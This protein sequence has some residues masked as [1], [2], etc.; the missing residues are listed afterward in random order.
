MKD[1]L[2]NKVDTDTLSNYATTEA[3]SNHTS[4]ESL[5]VTAEEKEKWNNNSSNTSISSEEG[6]I[7][8]KKSDGLYVPKTDLSTY[9]TTDDVEAMITSDLDL[10]KLA[11]TDLCYFSGHHKPNENETTTGYHVTYYTKY[12]LDQILPMNY[13]VKANG[14]TVNETGEI[15]LPANKVFLVQLNCRMALT[16]P[17]NFIAFNIYNKTE[18]KYESLATAIYLDYTGRKWSDIAAPCIIKTTQE[19]VIY[20]YIC[21]FFGTK[22]G[23]HSQTT[24][25]I[26]ELGS[27]NTINVNNTYAG[28]NETVLFDGNANTAKTDYALTDSIDNYDLIRIECRDFYEINYMTKTAIY[29]PADIVTMRT[30]IPFEIYMIRPVA[31]GTLGNQIIAVF[32]DRSTLRV[33]YYHDEG[34]YYKSGISRIVGIKK[35]GETV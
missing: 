19:T 34:N 8:E 4:D 11:G 20:A 25:T 33:N 26:I 18:N 7:V 35:G 24:I 27:Q 1:A 5:H 30:A 6:N 16:D 28:F 15:T 2:D 23:L 13:N 9:P 12:G 3:L 10:T 17:N 21:E 14:I 29:N 22:I 31:N 32:K